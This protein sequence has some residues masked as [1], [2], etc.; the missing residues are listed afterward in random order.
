MF[1]FIKFLQ[2]KQHHTV[3][4]IFKV[5]VNNHIPELTVHYGLVIEDGPVHHI[6]FLPSGGYDENNNRLGLMAV[7]T[8]NSVIK[9]YS[10]PLKVQEV[11]S[12][13]DKKEDFKENITLLEVKPKFVLNIDMLEQN[14]GLTKTQCMQICWSEVSY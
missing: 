10:L 1:K 7:A 8:I 12:E 2:P 4:L 14:Q 3:I 11:D 9:V 13:Q 5:I 6:S